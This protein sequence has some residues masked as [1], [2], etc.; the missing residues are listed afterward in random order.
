MRKFATVTY[1]Y[2][3]NY[4][5]YG[6]ALQTWALLRVLNS[7]APGEVEAVNLDYCPAS[8]LDKDPLNP[9]KNTWDTDPESLRQLELTMPAIR[10][11]YVKFDRFYHEECN[12]SKGS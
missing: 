3:C 1:N 11:N 10:E 7:L 2:H 4:T 8:H 6:S 5:N 9:M 12:L